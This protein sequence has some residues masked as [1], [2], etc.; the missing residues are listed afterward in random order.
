MSATVHGQDERVK[1]LR[2]INFIAAIRK[3]RLSAIFFHFKLGQGDA[4]NDNEICLP[5]YHN[6]TR[7]SVTTRQK[8]FSNAESLC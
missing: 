4:T 5:L 3:L 8:A 7:Q 6:G 1:E 2:A